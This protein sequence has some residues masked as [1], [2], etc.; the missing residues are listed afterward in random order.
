MM[1]DTILPARS[2]LEFVSEDID[3][4]SDVSQFRQIVSIL[5]TQ[6][7]SKCTRA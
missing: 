7:V 6:S 3:I 4:R 2:K 1:Q 5:R